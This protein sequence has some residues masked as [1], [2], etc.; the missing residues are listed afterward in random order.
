MNSSETIAIEDDYEEEEQNDE[1]QNDEEEND[2][3][4]SESDGEVQ[5]FLE[6]IHS[7]HEELQEA[8][9]E[10]ERAQRR[11]NRLSGL[12]DNGDAIM[13]DAPPPTPVVIEPD[14]MEG[15]EQ[16]PP[17]PNYVTLSGF[18]Q[19]LG[20]DGFYHQT[21]YVFTQTLLTPLP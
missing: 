19:V 15:V 7:A 20:P 1:E 14:D 8:R 18:L 12:D 11:F 16:S 10:F 3:E 6:E 13:P 21:R 17:Q 5:E 2:E 9:A 4:E